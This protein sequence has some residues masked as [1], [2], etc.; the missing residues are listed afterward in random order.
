MMQG[1][2]PCSSVRLTDERTLHDTMTILRRHLPLTATGYRCHTDDLWRLLVGAAA[3][4]TTLEALCADLVDAPHANTVRGHLVAQ[5]SVQDIPTWEQRWNDAFAAVMPAW[6]QARPQEVAVDCHD[7][8]YY[9]QVAPDDPDNWV[10]RGE[11]QAGTTSFYRCA[12]AYLM[13][14]D[15]RLTLAVVFVR[16]G[17]DKVTLLDRLLARVQ[18]AGVRIRCLYADKGFCNIPVLRWLLE[19]HL[20]VIVAAPIR[21]KQ[22]GT[23]ALCQG[24]T[25][26]RTTHT[27]QSAEHGAL[28]VPVTVVR[29]Y[30]RQRSGQ[31]RVAW[32]L[33]VCLG[34][35]ARPLRVRKRYRRRFGIESSYRLMEQVRARTT[36]PSPALRFLLMAL[37]LLLVN[38]WIRLQ[39]VH[40]RVVGRGPRRVARW[41]FRL[42]R[43]ARFLTRAIERYYGVVTAVDPPPT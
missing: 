33:Y 12:T 39:W 41:R 25:S 31:R 16:P 10:C 14:R 27:F 36:S 24:P 43:M 37:A 35:T 6:L 17:D 5:L 26:Y 19:Q 22:G 9:G 34:V 15:V 21:G 42:D 23:R 29:T 8:P 18:Q 28:T 2:T 13:L 11:A 1:P 40:L 20:P 38:V 3:R 4:H 7:E 30:Q 32:L